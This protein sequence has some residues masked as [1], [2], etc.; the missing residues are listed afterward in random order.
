VKSEK[1]MTPS[2]LK[3]RPMRRM[4]KRSKSDFS[5]GPGSADLGYPISPSLKI[6]RLAWRLISLR[7]RE[8]RA[9]W[10]PNVSPKS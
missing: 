1:V 5:C 8:G 6:H 10:R 4:G 2:P 9:M 3:T 7:H